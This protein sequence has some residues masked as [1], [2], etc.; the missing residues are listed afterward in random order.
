MNVLKTKKTS[1]KRIF[2]PVNTKK[3]TSA[4]IRQKVEKKAYELYEQR[5]CNHGNDITD[6]LEAER[7]VLAELA[8]SK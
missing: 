2:T 1:T 7:I 3:Y 8:Q 6:W 5:G 4:E